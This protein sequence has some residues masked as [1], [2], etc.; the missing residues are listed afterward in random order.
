M[1]RSK[2]ITSICDDVDDVKGQLVN[3]PVLLPSAIISTEHSNISVPWNK[4]I[5]AVA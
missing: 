4:L 5:S 3:Q 1:L 2:I